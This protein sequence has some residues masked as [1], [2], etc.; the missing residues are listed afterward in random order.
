M[1]KKKGNKA[2]CKH[3]H[4]PASPPAALRWVVPATQ[5]EDQQ[6]GIYCTKKAQQPLLSYLYDRE[7][8][9][10]LNWT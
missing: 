6:F 4:Y 8:N 9:S 2:A 5:A 3:I 7:Y 10:T 1:N